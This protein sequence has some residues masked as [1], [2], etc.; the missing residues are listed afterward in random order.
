M[1]CETFMPMLIITIAFMSRPRSTTVGTIALR[2]GSP[3]ATVAPTPSARIS[4]TPVVIAPTKTTTAAAS[5]TATAA[6]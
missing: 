6:N 1:I 4:A 2:T 3:T 5:V